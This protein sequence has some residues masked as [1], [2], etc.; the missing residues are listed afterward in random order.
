MS[1]FMVQNETIDAIVSMFW[2][3]E[4]SRDGYTDPVEA[5]ID[6]LTP[7]GR[8]LVAANVDSVAA[9]YSQEYRAE[10]VPLLYPRFRPVP[11]PEMKTAEHRRLVYG[12]AR[13]IIAGYVYQ[14]CEIPAWE[15]CD[16]QV[17]TGSLAEDISMATH[18]IGAIGWDADNVDRDKIFSFDHIANIEA[19]SY[20]RG[21]ARR[22]A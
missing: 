9:R 22:G 14:A 8:A 7:I 19:A 4:R 16:V 18:V 12:R 21:S 10:Q 20:M 5:A 11:I 6:V 2:H 13:G 1:C 3:L 15:G 17:W